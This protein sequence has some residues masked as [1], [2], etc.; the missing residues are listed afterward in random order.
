MVIRMEMP[1]RV[2]IERIYS[3]LQGLAK[4]PAGGSGPG[5][6]DVTVVTRAD[7]TRATRVQ[8]TARWRKD[9]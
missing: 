7:V 9:A 5:V 6:A 8:D 3:R 2:S 1:L 4:S